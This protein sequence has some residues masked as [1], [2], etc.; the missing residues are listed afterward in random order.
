MNSYIISRHHGGLIELEKYLDELSGKSNDSDNL[1]K[2]TYDWYT[3]SGINAVLSYDR[4]SENVSK[5][6]RTYKET[7]I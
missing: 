4:Y 3:E 6:R 1:G 7:H 2:R 5:L